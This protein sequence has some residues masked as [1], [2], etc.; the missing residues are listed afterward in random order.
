M[1]IK[2]SCVKHDST[3]RQQLINSSKRNIKLTF[4]WLTFIYAN[5]YNRSLFQHKVKFVQENTLKSVHN[6]SAGS[7]QTLRDWMTDGASI[8]VISHLFLWQHEHWKSRAGRG[9]TNK[10]DPTE[11]V[12]AMFFCFWYYT[13]WADKLLSIYI[14]Y[15]EQHKHPR[16]YC[17][18]IQ[19]EVGKYTQKKI[20]SHSSQTVSFLRPCYIQSHPHCSRSV[21]VHSVIRLA[22]LQ[23]SQSWTCKKK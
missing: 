13:L 11:D 23:Q 15:F 2:V 6:P 7:H 12:R 3:D 5:E 9:Q 17:M 4:Q 10:P 21:P 14:V 20:L 8:S 22:C 16:R 18:A 1:N 19:H